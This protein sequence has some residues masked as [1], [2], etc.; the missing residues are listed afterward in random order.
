M[1]RRVASGSST[2]CRSAAAPEPWSD[3]TKQQSRDENRFARTPYRRVR[4]PH[5]FG[6]GSCRGVHTCG[7]EL[8][9]WMDGWMKAMNQVDSTAD[10]TDHVSGYIGW[11]K[12]QNRIHVKRVKRLCL[13]VCFEACITYDLL[14]LGLEP[15]SSHMNSPPCSLRGHQ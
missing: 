1:S 11:I 10:W 12:G 3:S 14:S 15:C 8:D 7:L 13:F 2:R 4:M 6:F 9:G 5:M